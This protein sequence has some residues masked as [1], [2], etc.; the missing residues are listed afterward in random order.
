MSPTPSISAHENA[1]RLRR[2]AGRY[3][4]LNISTRDWKTRIILKD[5]IREYESAAGSIED[6]TERN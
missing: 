1:V 5:I 2:L 6:E 3:R 4:A